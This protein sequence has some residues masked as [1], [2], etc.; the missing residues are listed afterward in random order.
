MENRRLNP[1]K[2]LFKNLSSLKYGEMTD[3]DWLKEKHVLA[4]FFVCFID[5]ERITYKS[6]VDSSP[7]IVKSFF[8]P[9][10]NS[11]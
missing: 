2:F 4:I 8:F 3:V 9:Y 11:L 10:K 5:V 6:Q 1:K 7:F